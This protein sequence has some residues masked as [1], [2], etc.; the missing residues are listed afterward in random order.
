MS[1]CSAQPNSA[2]SCFGVRT[3]ARNILI[4]SNRNS[5]GYGG[6]VLGSLPLLSQAAWPESI[7]VST[8]AS[9]FQFQPEHANIRS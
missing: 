2:A 7:T 1:V 8:E 3:P 9:Q 4:A 6:L 5:S